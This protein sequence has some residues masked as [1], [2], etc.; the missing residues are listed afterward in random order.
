MAEKT[1]VEKAGEAVGFG[2]AMAED[3]AGA[4]KTAVG[5]AVATGTEAL[6][7]A[8][9]TKAPVK[10][11]AK[12]APATKAVKKP[13]TKMAG[14]KSAAKKAAKKTQPRRRRLRKP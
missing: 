3:V 14:K 9:A 10:R 12:K 7:K 4:V 13:G 6:K 5:A 11:A 2:I 1:M 8:P